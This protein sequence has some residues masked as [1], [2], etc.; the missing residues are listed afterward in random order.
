MSKVTR[1]ARLLGI[2]E[3]EAR[4]FCAEVQQ[5]FK[6][7]LPPCD[8]IADAIRQ[9]GKATPKEIA[10]VISPDFNYIPKPRP[11]KE[12]QETRTPKPRLR[13][14]FPTD[15]SHEQQRYDASLITAIADLI[16]DKDKGDR[17]V[18][19]QFLIDLEH[20]QPKVKRLNSVQLLEAIRKVCKK[21]PLDLDLVEREVR[22]ALY[23]YH[24]DPDQVQ[25]V[26]IP[27]G[28]KTN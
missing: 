23:G 18:A 26:S 8:V 14:S 3:S 22:K 6:A 28:G 5:H 20:R 17:I 25:V 16:S 27:M 7:V 12:E 11:P 21:G 1:V 2:T 10:T 24:G 4:K 15:K 9:H 13:K 19:E